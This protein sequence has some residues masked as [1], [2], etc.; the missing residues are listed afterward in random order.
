MKRQDSQ[1]PDSG[2][3]VSGAHAARLRSVDDFTEQLNQT[4]AF[5]DLFTSMRRNFQLSEKTLA[6]FLNKL[7][8]IMWQMVKVQD[9]LELART[10]T[11][12]FRKSTIH[13]GNAL[14]ALK[15]C[16]MY[17]NKGERAV[18]EKFSDLAPGVLDFGKAR[19][20]LQRL[21]QVLQKLEALES[22]IIPPSLRTRRE[23]TVA[24]RSKY[25]TKFWSQEFSVTKRSAFVK[26]GTVEELEKEL[27]KFTHNKASSLA[28]DRFISQV[29]DAALGEELDQDTVRTIRRRNKKR[30][31][32]ASSV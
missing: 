31:Q 20:A 26:H 13:Y 30:A 5:I 3:T 28:V 6:R 15:N 29:F 23:K 7:Y 27:L 25:E 10:S 14:A 17:L 24:A 1:P 32:V 18:Q 8:A 2:P 19:K 4:D 22:A 21:Q 12:M 16:I 11:A 9:R